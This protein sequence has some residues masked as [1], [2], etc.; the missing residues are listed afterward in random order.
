MERV[1]EVV[2]RLHSLATQVYHGRGEVMDK[3]NQMYRL[4][5][6]VAT[7]A[8]HWRTEMVGMV[9]Q[10]VMSRFTSF[11]YP[12]DD[13]DNNLEKQPFRRRFPVDRLYELIKC[14]CAKIQKRTVKIVSCKV[15]WFVGLLAAQALVVY[16]V[17]QSRS[18]SHAWYYEHVHYYP[19]PRLKIL[20]TEDGA[21]P[22]QSQIASSPR[23]I[24]IATHTT[25]DRFPAVEM[26]AFRW[27]GPMVLVV[28]VRV[29]SELESTYAKLE[30]LHS[31]VEAEGRCRLQIQIAIE[32]G[33][34]ND[35]QALQALYPINSMRNLALG[36]VTTQLVF[37][38]DADFVP[39]PGL[40]EHL[41][42]HEEK[43]ND[44]IKKTEEW[45][46]LLV[47]PAFQLSEDKTIEYQHSLHVLP[48]TK[49]ELREAW[50]NGIVDCFQCDVS[51]DSHQPTEYYRFTDPAVSWPYQV[52]YK[53]GY[54]PFYIA[55]RNHLPKFDDRFRG[56]GKNKI[57]HTYLL[58][59]KEFTFW[60]IPEGFLVEL[61]H[62][63]SL[64]EKRKVQD[65]L[66][67]WRIDG[68]YNR[69]MRE[70]NL[71]YNITTPK[72]SETE[73]TGGLPC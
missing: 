54:E 55:S 34:R 8:I 71:I 60:V 56:H 58:S 46:Q 45:N 43:F 68:I 29:L 37:L 40:H 67:T 61:P 24:T 23:E 65:P 70:I 32:E 5:W 53:E 6:L 13:D 49:E 57:S 44:L 12:E 27:S 26:T 20:T 4:M 73:K 39:N 21:P 9:K 42:Q 19:V 63:P 51:P 14:Q 2:S 11:Y 72:K 7:S 36:M 31:R 66:Q 15:V 52:W 17:H 22:I 64:S 1:R 59:V 3:V 41:T 30:L 10:N 62:P 50:W 16:F 18:S 38:V 69:S 47:V 48:H 28:L 25:M 35:G 33:F